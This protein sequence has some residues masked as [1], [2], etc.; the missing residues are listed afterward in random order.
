MIELPVTIHAI[1]TGQAILAEL[2]GMRR[3]KNHL[4]LLVTINAGLLG[5]SIQIRRVTIGAGERHTRR[6][7]DMC[8]QSK[9]N[10]LVRKIRGSGE[11][12]RSLRATM[13]GMAGA[14]FDPRVAADNCAMQP[15]RIPHFGINLNMA[16]Q[17]AL[18]HRSRRPGR[19]V[20]K[21]AL[22]AEFSVGGMAAQRGA[23][24][25]VE[26]S[27]GEHTVSAEKSGS[28]DGCQR[29]DR[30]ENG[31]RGKTTQSLIVHKVI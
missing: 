10:H 3:G 17:A 13:I 8:R 26:R 29:Y 7:V 23:R 12:Q 31:K 14:A 20:T 19:S 6:M 24:L 18:R 30:A 16:D 21:I 5:K 4:K 1:M 27:G 28:S 22:L 25:S 15:V 2:D 9:T 11:S